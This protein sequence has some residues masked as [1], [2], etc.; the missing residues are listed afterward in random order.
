MKITWEL[1]ETGKD[2]QKHPR[3]HQDVFILKT[4]STTD[5]KRN[6]FIVFKMKGVL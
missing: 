5:L 1:F 6:N 4:W 2:S 3:K